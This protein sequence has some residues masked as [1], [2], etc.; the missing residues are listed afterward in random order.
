MGCDSFIHESRLSICI[1]C[2]CNCNFVISFSK[3]FVSFYFFFFPHSVALP[4][5][6]SVRCHSFVMVNI[7]RPNARYYYCYYYFHRPQLLYNHARYYSSSF[8]P[9]SIRGFFFC[10]YKYNYFTLDHRPK[11]GGLFRREFVRLTATPPWV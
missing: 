3:S 4:T 10:S 8:S 6:L 11:V 2:H 5:Y 1:A 7:V 9:S